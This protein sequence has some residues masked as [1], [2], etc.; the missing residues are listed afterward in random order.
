MAIDQIAGELPARVHP[1]VWMG[2]VVRRTRHALLR[3]SNRAQ[4]VKGLLL[5]LLLPLGFALLAAASLGLSSGIYW[6][7]VAVAAFWITTSFALRA[8]VAAAKGVARP[9]ENGDLQ[10]AREGLRSL[11]SRDPSSLT[12][13]Q[14][15]AG[16][17]ES[18]S[19]NTSDSVVAP[20][21]YLLLFGVPGIVFYR[22]CN[23]LDAMVGYRGE[24]EYAGKASA[25]LDDVLNLVPA[26]ITAGLLV[27][28]G[29]LRGLN[30]RE[31]LRILKRDRA[32][33]ESP[34]AG[35]PMAALAGLLQVQLEKAGHYAL[36]DAKQPLTPGLVHVGSKVVAL[37]AWLW[38]V[39]TALGL[40]CYALGS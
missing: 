25:R 16:T 22:A 23:T 27:F 6:L 39:L 20:L 32:Q 11:C 40:A 29:A 34:N 5:A 12:E 24:Y 9:L 35:Y 36:G 28:A 26:R 30:A 1:V 8:L 21:F 10:G 18:I 14:L 4:F 2:G 31:A 33:T 3:G 15:L 38:F 13:S 17:L 7:E 19:E 37:A